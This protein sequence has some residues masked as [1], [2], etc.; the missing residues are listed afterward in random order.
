MAFD[1]KWVYNKA[2]VFNGKNYGYWKDCMC[3]HINFIDRNVRNAIQNGQFEITMTNAD[4][5]F[6]PK[7]EAQWNADDEKNGLVI[8]KARNILISIL[9]VDEYYRVSHC[10]TAKGM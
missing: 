5:V 10:E 6:V 3:I 1:P 8:W 7:S 9:G 4:D 2:P